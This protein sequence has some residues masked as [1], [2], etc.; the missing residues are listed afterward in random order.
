MQPN[1][2]QKY[3]QIYQ[4]PIYARYTTTPNI[5]KDTRVY[6]TQDARSTVK[7]DLENKR[8]RSMWTLLCKCSLLCVAV[9]PR[10]TTKQKKNHQRT[11][12]QHRCSGHSVLMPGALLPKFNE[13]VPKV[14]SKA[15]KAES[16]T[17]TSKHRNPN[18]RPRKNGNQ[19]PEWPEGFSKGYRFPSQASKLKARLKVEVP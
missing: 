11:G 3:T 2:T 10:A 12:K 1:K 13:T 8:S 15:T 5:R 6:V 9:L 16:K 17:K 19:T 14:T 7:V 18:L 4:I